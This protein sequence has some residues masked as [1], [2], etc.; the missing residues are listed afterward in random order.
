MAEAFQIVV[1]RLDDLLIATGMG[2]KHAIR[3]RGFK[4][5][6]HFVYIT[7]DHTVHFTAVLF[8]GKHLA[9]FNRNEG[10]KLQRAANQSRHAA[11]APTAVEIRKGTI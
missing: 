10:M 3:M 2:D 11:A 6:F 9:F 7:F 4:L 5:C 8:T 1:Y